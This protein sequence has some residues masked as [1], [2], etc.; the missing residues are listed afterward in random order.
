MRS[1][2]QTVT[3]KL[4]FIRII[5]LYLYQIPYNA[6]IITIVTFCEN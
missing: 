4:Q 2:G 6:I 5:T 1:N 3:R